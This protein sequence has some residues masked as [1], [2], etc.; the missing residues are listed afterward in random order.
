MFCPYTVF[1]S[2]IVAKKTIIVLSIFDE[3]DILLKNCC[4]TI[5]IKLYVLLATLKCKYSE[6][7][8]NKR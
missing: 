3:M 4:I 7:K 8:V 6:R 2:D 5:I 1:D